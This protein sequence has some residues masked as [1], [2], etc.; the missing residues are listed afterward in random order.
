MRAMNSEG[1]WHVMLTS[2][3]CGHHAAPHM[4]VRM[5]GAQET[6]LYLGGAHARDRH[7]TAD[8]A[9]GAPCQATNERYL[10]VVCSVAA[11]PCSQMPPLRS[12]RQIYRM[13]LQEGDWKE[14]G[15]MMRSI[16]KENGC[17]NQS[18]N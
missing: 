16:I 8:K 1:D 3:S 13:G 6:S 5:L 11:H 15:K 14:M 12:A 18:L 7:G 9:G 17:F 2:C 10:P 4:Q